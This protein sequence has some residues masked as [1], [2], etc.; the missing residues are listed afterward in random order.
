[1][2]NDHRV[3]ALVP[4]RAG[5]K[6]LVGKNL[7]QLAGR[8]I[9]QWSIDLALAA[10]EID[11]CV[12]STDGPDIAAEARRC[13]ASVHERPA[14]LAGDSSLVVETVREVLSSER[15]AGIPPDILLLLEPTAPFRI[16]SDIVGCLQGLLDGADSAATFTEAALHP[17]RAFRLDEGR[18]RPYLEDVIPWAPRQELTPPAYQS[19]G[20]VYALWADRLPPEGAAVLFGRVH[21]VLIP[22]AR[23]LDIDDALDLEL[24]DALLRRGVIPDVGEPPTA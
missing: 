23:C 9:L 24:A 14:H 12:V 18:V 22:R 3:L 10:P 19:A 1:M 7:R 6:G 4:A 20:A 17:K 16:H 5:S 21:P 11:R 8:S 15:A 2:L 13:G